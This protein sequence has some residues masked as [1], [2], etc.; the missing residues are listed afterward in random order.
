[1]TQLWMYNGFF[2][3]IVL[4]FFSMDLVK[5]LLGLIELSVFFSGSDLEDLNE[6][7]FYVKISCCPRSWCQEV[8]ADGGPNL[9]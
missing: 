2:G 3:G 8:T 4:L 1:M 9:A 5:Y 7:Y 6:D